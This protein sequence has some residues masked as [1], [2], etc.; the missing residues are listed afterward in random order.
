MVI[1]MN[2]GKRKTRKEEFIPEFEKRCDLPNL[3]CGNC[4]L[5]D[6]EKKWCMQYMEE[7][8]QHLQEGKKIRQD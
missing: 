4:L 3:F 8:R 6:K 5:F 1:M 7:Y 2:I